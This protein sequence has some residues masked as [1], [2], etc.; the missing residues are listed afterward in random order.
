MME[1]N[2]AL[3]L[4]AEETE[5]LFIDTATVRQD[6]RALYAHPGWLEMQEIIGTTG[7]A[8]ESENQAF[9]RWSQK[10]NEPWEMVFARYLSLVKRC[11]ALEAK[12]IALQS[13]LMGVQAKYIGAAA[14]EYADGRIAQGRSLEEVAESLNR[15]RDELETYT[16]NSMGLY[17]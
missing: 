15:S 17:D 5:Q 9:A 10:W 13:R 8:G 2:A 7:T 4:I 12:R 14:M 6:V 16:L 11:S 1:A 3:A